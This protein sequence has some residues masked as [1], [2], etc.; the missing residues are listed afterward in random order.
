MENEDNNS[1]IAKIIG[2]NIKKIRN[3][4]HIS[5]ETL[6]ELIGKSTHFISLLE[7]G[8]SGLSVGTLL[9]ICRALNID[10][11]SIFAGTLDNSLMYNNS[12]LHKSLEKFDD[13]SKEL[14]EHVINYINSKNLSFLLLKISHLVVLFYNCNR[15]K[16][17]G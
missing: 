13:S 1:N 9:D 2:N 5:Q 12:F 11:N 14:M 10:T 3:K 7:R 15:T 16:S 4:E 8:E 6:A 17:R